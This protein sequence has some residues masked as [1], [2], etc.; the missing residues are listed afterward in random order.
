[1]FRLHR[2]KRIVIVI[3]IVLCVHAVYLFVL[4]F[5]VSITSRNKF[6]H[7]HH[8]PK[9]Q[10]ILSYMYCTPFYATLCKGAVYC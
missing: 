7:Q 8:R 1:M 5:F 6:T 3:P 10:Y 4:F 2:I 9:G